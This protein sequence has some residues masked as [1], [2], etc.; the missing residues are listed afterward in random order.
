MLKS[1]VLEIFRNL[2]PD[3]MKGLKDFIRSPYHN[4]NKNVMSLFDIIKKHSPSFNDHNFTKELVFKKIFPGKEYNDI[5]MRI[6]LSDLNRI[7]EDF[8]VQQRLEKSAYDYKKFL[9][10]ELM[11]RKL[12][13]SFIKIYNN[14]T[15]N[16]P[17][18]Y[19]DDSYYIY[20]YDIEELNKGFNID[21][22][23]QHLN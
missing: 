20:K 1:K 17:E 23:L 15:F 4:K 18:N 13:K 11:E 3:E 9:L 22:N 2:S 7:T 16:Y 14:G 19:I 21:R 5:V 12:D 6:L 10:S 8:L